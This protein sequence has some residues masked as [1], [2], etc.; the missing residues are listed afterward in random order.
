[1]QLNEI[2]RSVLKK[3][4]SYFSKLQLSLQRDC[5]VIFGVTMI[6]NFFCNCVKDVSYYF[7]F[8]TVYIVYVWPV[9]E[10]LLKENTSN[11]SVMNIPFVDNKADAIL[12][13]YYHCLKLI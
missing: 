12:A 6:Y 4:L 10:L 9:S 8:C 11:F 5:S 7:F 1:M 2:Y 13:V 3:R